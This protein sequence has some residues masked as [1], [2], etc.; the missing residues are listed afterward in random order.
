MVGFNRRFSKYAREIKKHVETRINPLFIHYRM[1]AG[2]IPLDHWVHTEEGGGRII[3]EA[4]HII[5]LFSYLIDTPVRAVSVASLQPRTESVSASDNKSIVLE[6]ED[7]SVA[8]LEYFAVGSKEYP[9]E[10]MEIH[11]DEK[12]IVV[13][14]YRSIKGY[15]IQVSDISSPISDKGQIEELDGLSETLADPNG[16]WPISLESILETTWATFQLA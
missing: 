2:Y 6:Y 9:K 11:F 16:A 10:F 13:N 15:G 14:D 1:N 5:D 12:T 8:T 7:G 3:G 4:C